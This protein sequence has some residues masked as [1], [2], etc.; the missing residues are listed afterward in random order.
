MNITKHTMYDAEGDELVEIEVS[1]FG[2][3]LMQD[4]DV[5]IIDPDQVEEF[6]A[7][8]DV[9]VSEGTEDAPVVEDDQP[10]WPRPALRYEVRSSSQSSFGANT[11]YA[12]FVYGDR[13]RAY[14]AA[15]LSGGYIMDTHTGVR[16]PS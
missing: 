15:H 13:A 6:L 10:T 16:I 3:E 8:L 1:M 11:T 5:V 12:A 14:L 2:L 9:V 4:D 7:T